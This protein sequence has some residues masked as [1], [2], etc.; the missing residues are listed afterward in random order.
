MRSK[1]STRRKSCNACVASKRRCDLGLPCCGRCISRGVNCVYPW[2]A[3]DNSCASNNEGGD[4]SLPLVPVDNAFLETSFLPCQDTSWIGTPDAIN[5]T[6]S[7]PPPLSPAMMS[8]LSDI[9]GH[10]GVLTPLDLGIAPPT[11]STSQQTS[12]FDDPNHGAMTAGCRFQARSEYAGRRLAAQACALAEV[13]YTAFIHHTQVGASAVLQDAL[14]ASALHAMRNPANVAIVRTEIARRA[15]LLVD[16]V[17]A[18]MAC[19]PPIELDLLPPVQALLVYQCIRLFSTSD[20]TQQAQAER[21]GARLSAWASKLRQTLSPFGP[22]KEWT[23]WIRQ[24]SVRRT[25]VFTETISAVYAFLK[26]GWDCEGRLSHL[27]FTA[28]AALWEARSA[29]EWREIWRTSQRFELTLSTFGRD[30]QAADPEDF[31]ELGRVICAFY[32]GL[33]AL[34]EWFD[35][36]KARLKR[37]S[38][39]ENNSLPAY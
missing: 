27:G 17:E 8:L 12:S 32:R 13:G 16:A 39:R 35:G 36:D 21:D 31:D 37:W 6:P 11:N 38:L 23:D 4:S 3:P 26:L 33:D 25:V 15:G 22:V 24:E 29:A 28:Q 20:I 9:I 5:Y 14:A 10:G 7:V 2:G 18:A 19:N 1:L 34:E 30:T